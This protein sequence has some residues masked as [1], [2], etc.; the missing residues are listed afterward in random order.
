MSLDSRPFHSFAFERNSYS[1]LCNYTFV[2]VSRERKKHTHKIQIKCVK[3]CVV[4]R[5]TR[6]NVV[7]EAKQRWWRWRRRRE[8]ENKT[9]YDV[10][11]TFDPRQ[12]RESVW[13]NKNRI[14]AITFQ[15][16]IPYSIWRHFTSHSNFKLN[17]WERA[18]ESRMYAV[19]ST[20]SK[21]MMFKRRVLCI[22]YLCRYDRN[23]CGREREAI[24]NWYHLHLITD[25]RF[26]SDS[27]FFGELFVSLSWLKSVTFGCATSN[28]R[29]HRKI[30]FFSSVSN[31][32]STNCGF[33]DVRWP[34]WIDFKLVKV[35]TYFSLRGNSQLDFS[36][37]DWCWIQ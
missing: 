36:R 24:F 25:S 35:F 37:T 26:I 10:D 28:R 27:V 20:V 31:V 32:C 1:I 16:S 7:E 17:R 13:T 33:A 18:N 23:G 14:H 19:D 22:N 5:V 6:R 8:A 21:W 9:K 11:N 29:K 2:F 3:I 34:L 4:C 30:V 12:I 15:F